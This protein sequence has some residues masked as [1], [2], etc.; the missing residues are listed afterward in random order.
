VVGRTWARFF[1]VPGRR[2]GGR[3]GPMI[4]ALLR[5]SVRND[6]RLII[7]RRCLEHYAFCPISTGYGLSATR[8]PS[9]WT[10]PTAPLF[11]QTEVRGMGLP[12]WREAQRGL[13]RKAR[14]SADSHRCTDP[15]GRGDR[16][17]LAARARLSDRVPM[18]GCS[19]IFWCRRRVVAH[20]HSVWRSASVV[21]ARAEDR[22]GKGATGWASGM[23]GLR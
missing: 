9:R 1:A 6:D 23:N 20:A 8:S 16:I 5:P 22:I 21:L 7:R 19:A 11:T 13:H 14:C 3:G 2:R 18:A 12:Q 15:H 4:L 17:S 10:E